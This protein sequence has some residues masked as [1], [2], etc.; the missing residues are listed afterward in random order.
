MPAI[1]SH[2][3]PAGAAAPA[4]VLPPQAASAGYWLSVWRRLRRDP[5][6]MACA[7]ILRFW[8]GRARIVAMKANLDGFG[9]LMYFI[10]A[11]AAMDG[12]T[13]A[14]IEAPARVAGFLACAFGVSLVGLAAS[15]VV[16]RFLK[17]SERFMI[18]YGAGQRNMGMIVAALGAGV[19][20]STFLYFAL[21]Q[22]PIYLMP[23]LL[24]GVASRIRRREE[25]A[26][27]A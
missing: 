5:L 19:S 25:A 3:L 7:A 26:D 15:Y 21:A 18:G 1:V 11:I 27:G 20:P 14:A 13:R 17:R 16:L 24:G 22:F 6:A 4:F 2:S 10:F 9:V 23:W 8:W 12:V